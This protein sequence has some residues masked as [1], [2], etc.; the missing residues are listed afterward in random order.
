MIRKTYTGADI[1]LFHVAAREL[2]DATQW[3]VIATLNNHP[4]PMITGTIVLQIPKAD[5][6]MTGGVPPQYALGYDATQ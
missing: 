3:H 6:S 2:G 5:P 1:S 4:D